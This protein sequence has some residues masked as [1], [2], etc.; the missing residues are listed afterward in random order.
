MTKFQECREYIKSQRSKNGFREHFGNYTILK[1]NEL[2]RLIQS[3]KILNSEKINRTIINEK[4]FYSTFK[5]Y[6]TQQIQ[7]LYELY[8][9]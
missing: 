8:L 9:K 6:A 3:W 5:N 4:S 1:T 2:E 7:K